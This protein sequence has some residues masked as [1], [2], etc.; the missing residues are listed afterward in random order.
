MKPNPAADPDLPDAPAEVRVPLQAIRGRGA[1]TAMPHRFSRDVREVVDDG[2]NH[3]PQ[4]A[5]GADGDDD[6]GGPA[7]ATTV[8][9]ET[10]RSAICANDSPDIFFELSVNPY[11]GC[12]HGCVYCYARPT[13]SYLNFSPGLD[14]ETQIV[15]KHNIAEVLRRELA[16]PRYVPRLLNIGSATDCYQPVE[17][18]LRLTRGLIEVMRDARHP[19]SLI[20]K[21]SGVERDLDLLA[22]LAAQQLTAVY[23]TITTLDPLLARRMEPRAAA[24][25]R[26]LRTLRT[27]AEAGIPV[28]VSVA[29]QIPFITEDMEQVLEAARDAG[30]RSA[31]Y[32]VLR[33]PWELDAVFREWLQVH[34]PQR[35]ARVMARV[36]DLHNLDAAQ[37]SA[38][39][40]Y[41]SSFATRMKGSGLW[42]DMLRQ[43][44]AGAC[45]RLGLNRER[46]ELDLSQFRP[47]LAR[48]QGSLF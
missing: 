26:R 48:G 1:S 39:K 27:L 32:T 18:E 11:R 31:F 15:A 34:Y 12:E 38:G 20:T 9:L 45:R 23:V 43:R 10:A 25:H 40:S 2:W 5:G 33:L 46:L 30:A 29:P 3:G 42:A 24:P 47:G 21:S 16:Q 6:G 8:H 13:H 19:F 7:P 22:P 14:F 4:G 36:Q 28:G 41:D 17:R 35:A 44:F 37:R